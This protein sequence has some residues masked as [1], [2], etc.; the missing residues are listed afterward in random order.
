MAIVAWAILSAV[1]PTVTGDPN[2]PL[3]HGTPALALIAAAAALAV[4]TLLVLRAR[5][6]R[7]GQVEPLLAPSPTS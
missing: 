2:T 7:V 1:G 5:E 4:G 6:R 3:A